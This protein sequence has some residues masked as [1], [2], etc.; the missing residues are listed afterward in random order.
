[1]KARIRDVGIRRFEPKALR[2]FFLLHETDWVGLTLAQTRARWTAVDEF[3]IPPDPKYN[4]PPTPH[5]IRAE[6]ARRREGGKG[7]ADSELLPELDNDP[8]DLTLE[9][10]GEE[11]LQR[12]AEA[13]ISHGVADEVSA[14]QRRY[15]VSLLDLPRGRIHRKEKKATV[16]KFDGDFEWIGR[17]RREGLGDEWELETIGEREAW[18]ELEEFLDEDDW[19]ALS[20][21]SEANE[22]VRTDGRDQ[23]VRERALTYAEKV[24]GKAG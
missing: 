18:E 19:E 15:E 5:E 14:E 10:E 24:R 4:K 21:D 17:N 12:E 8:R 16:S 23:T 3:Y 6:A 2:S 1:M 13:E 9:S 7:D 11:E 20:D 22:V